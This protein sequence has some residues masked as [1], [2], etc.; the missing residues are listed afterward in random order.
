VSKISVIESDFKDSLFNMTQGKQYLN[1]PRTRFGND[2]T[3]CT[4]C[5]IKK[6]D[7]TQKTGCR[8]GGPNIRTGNKSSFLELSARDILI[9]T[10]LNN[11]LGTQN[12]EISTNQN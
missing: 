2:D 11:M 3:W 12:M 6:P 4:F 7:G 9:K 5:G 8:K 10:F 1:Q